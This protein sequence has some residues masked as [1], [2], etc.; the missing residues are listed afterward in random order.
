LQ[1]EDVL[2]NPTKL[3]IKAQ[4]ETIDSCYFPII[5]SGGVYDI[6]PSA[7]SDNNQLKFD[8]IM[9]S[10]GA[11]YKSYC[12][13]IVRTFL[14]DPNKYISKVYTLL[15]NLYD[16]CIEKML[17]GNELKIVYETAQSFLSSQDPTLLP[18]L[19]KTF[20]FGIG[21]EY[22]DSTFTLNATNNL[23]FVPG[24]VFAFTIG[25]HNV[26]LQDKL[27]HSSMDKFSLLIGDTI[28]IQGNNMIPDIMTKCSKALTD[29]SYNIAD[30]GSEDG[31]DDNNENYED[32][33]AM[34]V[35]G[36]VNVR[37][38]T[39]SKEEKAASES[40][41]AQRASRQAE[42]MEK[43]IV[44][45]RK[46]LTT[47]KGT[48]AISP[49]DL[50]QDLDTYKSTDLYPK[51]LAYNKIKID[52][53][54]EAILVPINGIHVPFHITTIKN[55]SMPEADKAA[56][57]RI[58][59]YTPGQALG[60]DVPKNIQYLIN[61]YNV[62][63]SF[64]KELTF[65]SLDV[66]SLTNA[67]RNILE[68]RKRIKQRELKE[69]IERDLVVQAKLQRIRD[70]RIPRL[71]DL[72]MRPTISGKK[73]NGTLEAHMNGLRFTTNKGEIL[74]VM[75]ANIK[76]A[77]FQPCQNK[78]TSVIIHFNLKDNIMIG[79][80]KYKDVQFYTEVIEASLNLDNNKRNNYDIDELD[81]EQRER[82]LKKKINSAFKEFNKKVEKIA[83]HYE[84]NLEFD[85]PYI[86]LGFDGTCNKEMVFIMPSVRC[87]VN[88]TEIPFF[89]IDLSEVEHVHFERVDFATRNFDMTFIF[90]NHEILPRTIASIEMR[91]YE[92][93]QEWL[94]DVA[95]TYTFGAKSM[96]WKNV[97]EAVREDEHFYDSTDENGEPKE[98]SAI[99]W[100]I[101]GAESDSEG[102][103]EDEDDGDEEFSSVDEE[104]ES[105]SEDSDESSFEDED[106]DEDEYTD[107]D[108]LSEDGKVISIC[109]YDVYCL[110]YT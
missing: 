55:V 103:N 26:P 93:I 94:S 51:D 79:K 101:L 91:N 48:D 63:T 109:L 82:E 42:L 90:Y 78:S 41:A 35:E 4:P 85:I 2:Y 58:N 40:A 88:L 17:V 5:Q 84:F 16:K 7:K 1:V 8:I 47:G 83:K 39:R 34:D 75:Y 72:V 60:K 11:R 14:I 20:G 43:K 71:Q 52:L 31:D 54:N 36:G 33:N 89:V 73:S 27:R 62:N 29:I 30:K 56:Y 104:E 21:L 59:F 46:R 50:A 3:G 32:E 38:S 15:I 96:T 70:E 6:K 80:K 25:F 45:A 24:M 37:R 100:R 19:P 23:R 98:K 68:L 77:L 67:Y 81:E 97:M 61:K 99:G 64:I 12:S 66:K 76:H 9:C 53:D 65:R 105:E 22:K 106:E 74:D 57:L 92:M 86:D 49:A 10:L 110:I 102:D 107:E 69:E 95:I 108:D 28:L 87:L 18:Y 44:E 13:N